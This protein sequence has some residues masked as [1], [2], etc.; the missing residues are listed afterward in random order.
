MIRAIMSTS[1]MGRPIAGSTIA[2]GQTPPEKSV[3]PVA[4]PMMTARNAM[5]ESPI[6]LATMNA[7]TRSAR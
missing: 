5:I 4:V 3:T 1:P 2:T 7:R 6:A